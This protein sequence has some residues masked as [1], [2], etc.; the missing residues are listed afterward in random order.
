MPTTTFGS[1]VSQAASIGLI[2]D[3]TA[4][5]D[6]PLCSAFLIGDKAAVT[7]ASILSPYKN[8]PKALKVTFPITRQEWGVRSIHMHPQFD[9]T[10][11]ER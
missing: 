7:I 11:S 4:Y 3:R 2:Y 9:Q 10:L 6:E 5:G 1:T 8:T